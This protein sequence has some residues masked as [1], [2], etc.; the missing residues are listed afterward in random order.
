MG[1]YRSHQALRRPPRVVDLTRATLSASQ[2]DGR[3][4]VSDSIAKQSW[5]R[6][7]PTRMIQW[8]LG[9]TSRAARLATLAEPMLGNIGPR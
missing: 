1:C 8:Q 6:K 7:R 9:S 2:V 5:C 4:K 3:Q